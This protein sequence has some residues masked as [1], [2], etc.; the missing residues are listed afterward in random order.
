MWAE[1]QVPVGN[2]AS[3]SP[4][5]FA[6]GASYS[7][8]FTSSLRN[9]LL[10]AQ[11]AIK[12]EARGYSKQSAERPGPIPARNPRIKFK[13]DL[14]VIA[15]TDLHLLFLSFDPVDRLPSTSC[16]RDQGYADGFAGGVRIRENGVG[17]VDFPEG[18]NNETFSSPHR[19]GP[20]SRQQL[21]NMADAS[22]LPARLP[23]R[24][25]PD[26]VLFNV[27]PCFLMAVHMHLF[28]LRLRKLLRK[29]Y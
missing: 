4:Q 12:Y 23:Q 15:Y 6:A 2:I 29:L 13:I 20:F 28:V 22:T 8:E 1:L 3:R 27:T 10:R 16:Y 7:D 17:K 5:G 21:T 26:R 24:H 25:L 18:R 14:R 9:C 11:R 19:A